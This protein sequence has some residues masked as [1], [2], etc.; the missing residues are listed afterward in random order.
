MGQTDQ[1]A[2]F[3]ADFF[4][5]G[6]ISGLLFR[7]RRTARLSFR[8]YKIVFALAT[9]S[10]KESRSALRNLFIKKLTRLRVI[11]IISANV[12]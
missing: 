4:G 11:P 1:H 12:S 6:I 8:S 3:T 5:G 7:G 10:V 2:C 9:L